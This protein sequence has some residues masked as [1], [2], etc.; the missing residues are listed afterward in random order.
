MALIEDFRRTMFTIRGDY[1]GAAAH[2]F[3]KHIAEALGIGTEDESVRPP[4]LRQWVLLEA[5][6]FHR[7]A[8]SKRAGQRFQMITQRTS[9]KD[10]QTALSV[11]T[12]DGEPAQ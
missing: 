8:I 5:Q 11:P 4:E 9:S 1:R 3:H 10:E 6:E 12:V 2:G 7:V